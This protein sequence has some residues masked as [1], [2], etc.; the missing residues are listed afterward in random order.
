[1]TQKL[2]QDKKMIPNRFYVNVLGINGVEDGVQYP[3]PTVYN[4]IIYIVA[5]LALPVLLFFN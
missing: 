3:L 2:T 1:M 5:L 4:L